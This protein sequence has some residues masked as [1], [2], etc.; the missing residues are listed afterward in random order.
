[1]NLHV[2]A[3]KLFLSF[4]KNGPLKVCFTFGAVSMAMQGGYKLPWRTLKI[5]CLVS[6]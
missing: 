3:A 6:Q 1:M 2:T 5:I 4:L